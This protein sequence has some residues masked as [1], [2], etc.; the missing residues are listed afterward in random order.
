MLFIGKS[1]SRR[2]LQRIRVLQP[3]GRWHLSSS[4]RRMLHRSRARVTENR[5]ARRVSTSARCAPWCTQAKGASRRD[6]AHWR[7]S[8]CSQKEWIVIASSHWLRR[9]AGRRVLHLGVSEIGTRKFHRRGR[10]GVSLAMNVVRDEESSPIE[11][12]VNE[13]C[14]MGTSFFFGADQLRAGRFA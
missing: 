3:R 2:E 8:R 5:R 7:P 14:C 1:N 10:H 4:Y 9:V 6:V 12:R 13:F 11:R